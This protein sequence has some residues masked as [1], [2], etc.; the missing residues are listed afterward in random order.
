VHDRRRFWIAFVLP[1]AF[2][3]VLAPSLGLMALGIAVVVTA[4]LDYRP[5][6][7]RRAS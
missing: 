3:W 6:A 1:V 4:M 7:D 5:S 2:G